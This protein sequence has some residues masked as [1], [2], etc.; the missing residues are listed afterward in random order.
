MFSPSTLTYFLA[1]AVLTTAQSV[2]LGSAGTYAILAASTITSTGLTI[3][4]GD[5]GVSPGSSVTGFPPGVFTGTEHLG[6]PV[7]AA[8]EAD[9]GT[10]Y[11][12]AAALPCGTVL[13]GQDLGGMT[14]FPGVYCFSTSA[15]LNGILTL[16]AQGDPNAIFVF[17]I[18]TTLTAGTA[19]QVLLINGAQACAVTWQVGSSATLNIGTMFA[20]NIIAQA[21]VSVLS[22]VATQ[23][24]LY[25]LSGAVTLIDDQISAVGSCGGGGGSSS[26]SLSST[27]SS[28]VSSTSNSTTTTTTTTTT[29]SIISTTSS[30]TS[31]TKFSTTAPATCTATTVT[32]TITLPWTSFCKV[33]CKPTLTITATVT[34]TIPAKVTKC[35]GGED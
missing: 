1:Y 16:D 17:Q 25:A 10:A 33:T 6:D 18:G 32:K 2:N 19:A 9:A 13:S 7:A 30:T 28:S 14:L 29:S 12:Q 4:N 20:G 22:N 15:A 34:V 35:K 5:I 24:G 31:S 3:A 27:S 21:S 26:S 11:G 8:A 23:G